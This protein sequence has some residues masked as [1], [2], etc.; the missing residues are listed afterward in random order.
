MIA[1]NEIK[2]HPILKDYIKSYWWFSIDASSF[3]SFDILPDGY[4]DLLIVV[5]NGDI[6][7][8]SLTGIW[9]KSV[10]VEYTENTEVFAIRFKPLAIGTILNL[11]INDLLDNSSTLE[12][13][14]IGLDE[15][16]I[17]RGLKLPLQ[18]ITSKLNAHFISL[19]KLADT[20]KRIKKLFDIVELNE[21]NESVSNISNHIGLS[22][23]QIQRK[24]NALLGIGVKEYSQI[25]RLRK[26]LRRVKYDK[27]DFFP[28]FD[29]SHFIRELKEHTGYTPERLDLNNNV[30]FI[31]YYRF[32][33]Q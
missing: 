32:N 8:V 24:M 21:G 9:T 11:T 14:D 31:Q 18:F 6:S 2:P 25:V 30:R 19:L 20:D 10:L 22:A 29:Q 33:D 17:L 23:R 26:T 27:N 15:Q 13:K 7:K 28:Y 1:Y 3:Q 12:L 4:F 5:K 16:I